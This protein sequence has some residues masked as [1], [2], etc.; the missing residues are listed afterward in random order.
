MVDKPLAMVMDWQDENSDERE[1]LGDDDEEDDEEEQGGSIV[2]DLLLLQLLNDIQENP[3]LWKEKLSNLYP[4]DD[5]TASSLPVW[6]CHDDALF[7]A[8]E[9]KIQELENVLPRH[10]KD[11]AK[12]L[13]LVVRY[14]V[15][16]IETCPE[17]LIH[18]GPN[19]HA[20][21]SGAG[22]YYL[23][24]FFNHDAH[25]NASR[26]AV[27]DVMWFVANQDIA[28]GDEICISYLEHDVLC[29]SPARRTAMLD[30]DFS[31]EQESVAAIDTEEDGP[32]FPVVDSEVQNELM[33]M[34]VVERLGAI[35]ELMGQATG[36]SLPADEIAEADEDTMEVGQP[37]WF[38]CDA[39]NLR[40]IKAITL[41]GMGQSSEALPIWEECVS[42]TERKLPP[43]DESSIVMHVQ[44]ALCAQH[45][46]NIEEA[47]KHA[48]AAL[49][50]HNLIFGGGISRF[51]RRYERELKMA[52]RPG[53]NM[54][55]DA[56]VL[57]PLS[58]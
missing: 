57:W 6:I 26:W 47:K 13:P 5:E 48:A 35:E 52:L 11:I 20:I 2:N 9:A 4:R 22:I 38:Q 27:G 36:E 15:L 56:D 37:E 58:S 18:P 44:A 1:D 8:I 42:F 50:G 3:S 45:A 29:E 7:V 41:E 40:I 46:G 28:Q 16:S 32:L 14:N 12:R 17:L 23:P 54:V 31:E 25:P 55:A 19:G 51:R 24:S 30:M 21:L 49:E 34:D 43:N 10:A 53:A 33:T 39:H